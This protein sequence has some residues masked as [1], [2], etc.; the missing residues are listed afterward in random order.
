MPSPGMR[1]RGPSN[2][3]LAAEYQITL[4]NEDGPGGGARP[5][6][7]GDGAARL[8]NVRGCDNRRR[9]VGGRL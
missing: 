6:E 9:A 4:P 5:Y 2:K 3:V 8:G 7:A 1:L